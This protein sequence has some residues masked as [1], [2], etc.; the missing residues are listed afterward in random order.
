MTAFFQRWESYVCPI[1]IFNLFLML[2]WIKR[3]LVDFKR[4]MVQ[5]L[6]NVTFPVGFANMLLIFK[7]LFLAFGN[8]FNPLDIVIF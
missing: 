4:C 5:R 8:E 3:P 6:I 7:M 1:C 2:T